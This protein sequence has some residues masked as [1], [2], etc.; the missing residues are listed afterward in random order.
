[1]GDGLVDRVYGNRGTDQVALNTGT[2]FETK[3]NYALPAGISSVN[4]STQSPADLSSG[5]KGALQGASVSIGYLARSFN[6]G[7]NINN[8][9]SR[10]KTVG[11]DLNGDGLSDIIKTDGSRHMVYL[12]TGTGY[13]LHKDGTA[14]VDLDLSQELSQSQSFGM[15]GNA[16]ATIG[17]PIFL[18]GKLSISV[19][20]GANYS[21]NKLRSSFMDINGDGAVDFVDGQENGDL[22][23][24]YSNVVKSNYLTSVSN[25]LGGSFDIDYKLVG[26][27]RGA[28]DAEVMTHRADEKV[29]WDMPSG[30][31][32]LAQVTIHDGVNIAT[33]GGVDLDGEDSM[34]IFF[35]YDGGIQ[36]R[37][38]KAFAGFTR[39][40]TRQQNQAGSESSYPKRYL[41][42]VVEYLAPSALSF[43]DLVKH[44][45]QKGLVR[46]TYALY[47]E[48][49]NA[50]SHTVALISAQN[51][52]YNFRVVDIVDGSATLGQVKKSGTSFETVDWGTI[53]ESATVF[54][55]VTNSEALN[56][57][58]LSQN[59]LYHSQAFELAYDSYFNVTRYQDKAEMTAN[60]ISETIEETI[61]STRV[62]YHR[63]T[64]TCSTLV[65]NTPVY[66]DEFVKKYVIQPESGY[67]G[68]SVDTLWL[69]DFSGNCPPSNIYGMNVCG[70][71][72]GVFVTHHYK[73]TPETTYV[74][75]TS[76]NAVYNSDRIAVMDYFT[77]SQAGGRTGV[78]KKHSIH[79]G[80]TASNPVR[81]SEVTALTTD[82]KSVATMRTTLNS[83]E[84]AVNDLRYDGYGNVTQIQGPKNHANQRSLLKYTYD[85]TLHQYVTGISNQFNESVCNTYDYHTGQLLQTIGINGHPMVYE[86]DA[87]NRLEK[88][89]APREIYIGNSAPTIQYDYRLYAVSSGKV[90]PARA[91]TTHNLANLTNKSVSF[92]PE[93][94]G[95]AFD[96]SARPELGSGVRTATFVDG[97]A[98]AVQLQTEQST[99]SNGFNGPSFMISGPESV[100]KF[101]RTSQVYADFSS[102]GNSSGVGSF[103]TFAG[104]VNL[105]TVDLMQKDVLYDYNNRVTSSDTWTA[106]SGTTAGQWVTTQMQYDWNDDL[107]SG[108]DQYYEKT[109]VLSQ[110]SGLTNSTPNIINAT[111]TDARGRKVGTITYGAT[112]GDDITT[113]FNYNPIGELIEVV[114]PIGL[115]TFYEYD[116]A[117]RVTREEHPDRGMTVTTYD[118]ASNVTQI[119]TPGSLAFGGSVTM[120]YDYNRLVHKYM[121]LSSGADLYDI[122]YTY[123]TKG[124]GRN[125]AGRI[126]QV[127]QGQGFKTDL[128]RYDELGN[129]VEENTTIDVPLYGYKGF[130]TT[131]RYDSFGRI[132][133]AT[134]PDGDQVTYGYTALGEL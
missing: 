59:T 28:Y 34:Q 51:S 113:Q 17:I 18:N 118:P 44:D 64:N 100:D 35:D 128:L 41:T 14:T 7:I 58:Q 66:Q 75:K 49:S 63:Q 84:Y 52:T 4:E 101:G 48:E 47:H 27:R 122:A 133:Q 25:P 130:T 119:Q 19:N 125:G 81:E 23:V 91:I 26:H 57:P 110:A 11:M 42:E 126:T 70:S 38:E 20:G 31:W 73:E 36:N 124:D 127:I 108:K 87:F 12:N 33:D 98:K 97:N 40:E 53:G 131:K 77:P 94:C 29:L 8:S 3:K 93:L 65:G 129:V 109:S 80:S 86:Y 89:W 62:E 16:G 50:T 46:G 71:D 67:S 103:G 82:K 24:Y 123:G 2:S 72:L 68:Y 1:N 45:Y 117:G 96:F 32:V 92:T 60:G 43:S 99:T 102:I 61:F 76:T 55:A 114:D 134:Y 5:L 74:K 106:E 10:S 107:I 95:K 85:A 37:R 30:K 90:V 104:V 105:S 79:L 88:V 9:G 54:P 116:L 121:P 120:E 15:S 6:A 13:V 115:S 56:I 22:H 111:Y 132:L 21:V 78:L 39:V 112:A 69:M 83:T